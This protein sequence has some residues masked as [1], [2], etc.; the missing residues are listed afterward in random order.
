MRGQGLYI[1]PEDPER[2]AA[3]V[4]Y[5]RDN[6]EIAERVGASGRAFV[7]KHFDRSVLAVRYE[8]LLRGVTA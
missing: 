7:E 3:A 4:L 6:P 8:R 5:L 1:P 2:L